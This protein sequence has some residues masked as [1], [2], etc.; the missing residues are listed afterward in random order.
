MLQYILGYEKG[1]HPNDNHQIAWF[2]SWL[3]V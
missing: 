1:H 3:I 2:I